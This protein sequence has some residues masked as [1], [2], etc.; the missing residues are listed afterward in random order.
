MENIHAAGSVIAIVAAAGKKPSRWLV[1]Q[2]Y[3]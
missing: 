3:N 2:T 1:K